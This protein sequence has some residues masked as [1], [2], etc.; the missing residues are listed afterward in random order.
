MITVTPTPSVLTKAHVIEIPERVSGAQMP[1]DSGWSDVTTLLEVG[2]MIRDFS[3]N[4]GYDKFLAVIYVPTARPENCLFALNGYPTRW[5][6][7]YREQQY[8]ERD[9]VFKRQWRSSKPFEWSDLD[10]RELHHPKTDEF[11]KDAMR[12]GLFSGL[13]FC[14]TSRAGAQLFMSFASSRYRTL[15]A[16]RAWTFGA[17]LLL[18]TEVLDAS[19]KVAERDAH[20]VK[21]RLSERQLQAL[22]YAAKGLAQR[23]IALEMGVSRA[24]VE[25]L[26]RQAQINVGAATREEAILHA[27]QTGLVTRHV[28]FR[29]STC[30]EG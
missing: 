8:I 30:E 29:V 26:I 20:A 1:A 17:A 22:Q 10:P 18:G 5:L 14:S 11:L 7:R 24:T 27:A 13:S 19:V 23:E 12:H 21:R 2:L 3:G 9:P 15:G 25:Y 4:I 16:Q 28:Q 6:D